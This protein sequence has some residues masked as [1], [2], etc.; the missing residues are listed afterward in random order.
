[1]VG[2][3][4]VFRIFKVRRVGFA[5]VAAKRQPAGT[6]IEADL[7][8]REKDEMARERSERLQ[9]KNAG[10]LSAALVAEDED[11]TAAGGARARTDAQACMGREAT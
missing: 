10:T 1:M 5:S 6:A 2:F 8:T 9:K 3:M 4:D 7:Q 11:Q